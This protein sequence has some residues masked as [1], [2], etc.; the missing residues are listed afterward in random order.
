MANRN[1]KRGTTSEIDKKQQQTTGWL[2]P[3]LLSCSSVF[4][5]LSIAIASLWEERANLS[6]FSY[7]CSICACSVSSVSSSS[8]CLGRACDCDTSWSFLL[9][10]LLTLKYDAASN[11]KHIFYPFMGPILHQ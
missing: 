11:C 10:F 3:V 2:K 6:A 9:P 4:R 5:P 1:C 7:V 8:S